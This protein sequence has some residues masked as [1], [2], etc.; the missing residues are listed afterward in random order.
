[1][2][3]RSYDRVCANCHGTKTREGS[4]PTSLR[5]GSGAFKNGSDPFRI[6]QT[7]TRGFGLMPPQTWMV[8]QQKY[9]VIHYIREA[10][11]RPFNPSQYAA[12]TPEYLAGLPRGSS[13]GPNPKAGAPWARRWRTTSSTSVSETKGP[14]T[15]AILPPPAM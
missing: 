10:F 11:L 13:R 14:C 7:L 8:P 3:F 4:L 2:L 1:M 5:F 9:D 12:V 15:R 6:Y